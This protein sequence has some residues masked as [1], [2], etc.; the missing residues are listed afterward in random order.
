MFLV[1]SGTADITVPY[2]YH[3]LWIWKN[4]SVAS[5]QSGQSV[6][7]GAG[8]GTLGYEWDVD[9]DNG[10][11]P[12]GEFDLSSTT[13]NNVQTFTDYGTNTVYG[14]TATHHLTLY[15]AASGALVFGAGTVQ[16]AWGLNNT[17]AWNSGIT[18][19]S[20][21]PPDPNMEQATVNL[22][23]AMGARPATLAS[24]LVAGATTTDVTPPKST[25]TSPA[26]GANLSDGSKVTVSGTA[27]DSGGGVVAGVEISSDGGSTWHPATITTPD[28]TTVSW[29]Y[30]WIAHGYPSTTIETRAVDDSGNLES[31]S[32]AISVNIACPCS[33]WGTN[34]T[35][36]QADSGD[37]TSITAGLKFD[38]STFG[39]VTGIRF[40]KAS[41]N[42]GTHTGS[43]WSS[44]GQLLASATFTN[45]T[46]SGW[47]TVI[48]SSPV[49]IFPG[50][51]Y[52]AS[53]FAPSGHYSAT[54]SY[55]YNI[56]SPPP[57]GGGDYDSPPLQAIS[58]NTSADGVYSVGSSN[59][60][61][62]NTF[63]ASNYWVDPIF[64]P[65]PA[66]GQVTNVSAVAGYQ[67]A[68]ISWSAPAS[69][70]Q[71]TIYTITPYVGSTPQTP[72]TVNGTPP[73]TTVTV[74]GLQQNTTYTF[75]VQAANPNGAGPA[76][77]ASSPVIVTGQAPPFPPTGV[78]AI[79]ANR[80]AQI[81]WTAPS[82]NNG[83][84]ITAYT[85]T[86]YVNGTPQA[87]TTVN[88]GSATSG[89][90]TGLTNNIAYTFTVAATNSLGTGVESAPSTSVT[91]ENTI[92]DFAAPT[93]VD[94][95]DSGS[96]EL[97]VKFTSDVG[98]L[99]TGIRFYKAST[100]T[101]THIGNL[102]TASGQ[103]LASATF[104]NETASG[105][106]TVLFS[107]PV[108]ISANT[109]YV[110]SYFD[111]NGH[112]SSTPAGLTN[113]V[114]SPPLH[115]LANG[116]SSNGV[117]AYSQTST[118]PT[119]SYNANNYSVDVL[120]APQPPGQVTNVTATADHLA[121]NVSW[122]APS[123]GGI[124][125][126]VITP[127]IGSTAQ[128]PT[129]VSGTP[130]STSVHV[131]GLTAGTAYTFT[132]QAVNAY[133]SGPASAASGSVTPTAP[134][135]PAAPTGVTAMIASSQAVLNWTAP[136][137]DG[138][139]ITSY[140]VTPYLGSTAQTPVSLNNGSAT[141]ATVTGLTNGASYTFTVS[142]ANAIGTGP[143]STASSPVTPED[144]VFDFTT[145]SII[146]SG[147]PTSTVLGVKFTS[148]TAGTI[149]GI[150]FYKAPT[151]T[152]THIGSLWT[153]SGTLLASATYTNETASGWQTVLFANPVPISA[154]TIYVASYFDPN[155]HYSST[156]SGLSTSIDNPPLHAISSNTSANGL[157]AYS[158]TSIF[159]TN[160]YNANSYSVD[161]LFQ[162]TPP[163]QPTNVT[164][165]AG[166]Q[167]ATVN[168][169]APASGAVT[170]YTVTPY[171]G[172]AAQSQT[173]VTGSPP[174]TSTTISNLTAGTAY[175]FTVQASNAYGDGQV[176]TASNSVTPSSP[177]APTSP[178][179]VSGTPAT[180]EALVSWT[181]P[182]SSNGS[183]IT[184]YTVTPYI[185]ATAQPQIQVNNG[186]A[187][188]TT[189]TGLTN[190]TAYTFTVSATNG[191]GTSA[192][193]TASSAVTP[194]D[195]SLDFATPSIADSG[196]TSSIALGM[197]FTSDVAG[198]VLGVR[199]YKGSNNTGTHIGNLWTASGTLLA[200]AT[201]TNET[202]SGWQ[203]VLFSNP[204]PISAN[205]TYVVSYFAP[206]GH[207]SATP[208]GLASSIDN[209]PLHALANS[210]SANGLYAYSTSSIFPTN[211]YNANSYSVDVLFAPSS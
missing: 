174:M 54:A 139:P 12:P 159:P 42:T 182:S 67:S 116:T 150:R 198:N 24:G 187:T 62:V 200:T 123:T 180:G 45:E 207:Y 69:G 101:S 125:K 31:P 141:S 196:D 134:T 85:I 47:Q 98:G 114:D 89:T 149:N 126:Y 61:P 23:A 100:N 138:S 59:T 171:I 177:A 103:L 80:Q 128:T 17:N 19:P 1:N 76:S 170:K 119:N 104:T 204:V 142:A 197:K 32:D 57:T 202:S 172:S 185:G 106:Q 146:D 35:P 190:G 192:Q 140:T 166:L 2:Q 16:W 46:A 133:G 33:I 176:S 118:F 127:Y 77:A 60:F 201:F 92:F 168:W 78:S 203:T 64:T 186:S 184:S 22:L 179:G 107:K 153:A 91:P 44:S 183:A 7:L 155:G 88:N 167:S 152:G 71:A 115:A 147:D 11:R 121:A 135:A 37:P 132:V 113:S 29:T 75:K 164:A 84:A 51:T 130:P 41:T 97:G 178:T 8:D 112:Y 27:T 15:R 58:N 173:T 96:A 122:S 81:S 181:T 129:T 210:T 40:Y 194:E 86:P 188:S 73:S 124:T 191:I 9:A 65:V 161:V 56:P 83:S 3:K 169:S 95:N 157:Y 10:F 25:I 211:T 34:V 131:S 160:S 193:S 111:P 199:F 18:E 208:G 137:T 175:T 39:T 49:T 68:Q 206:N 30:T 13:V 5:L 52:V 21:N 117:Y 105:W 36:S 70:G 154:G 158:S 163:G 48:F 110:A 195:T 82:N 6:T 148:D 74:S 14:S 189:V 209:P 4:T 151:N 28:D 136:D 79:P 43:L 120:F 53:Y 102:W 50:T 205:T 162:P 72:T 109:T 145:P 66:P 94:A 144:T 93:I 143:A 90:V 108:S 38:S 165:T 63:G 156:P 87:T 20:N 26:A 55:F 99:V